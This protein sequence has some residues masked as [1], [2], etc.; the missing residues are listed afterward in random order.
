[1]VWFFPTNISFPVGA[2]PPMSEL[3]AMWWLC[4]LRGQ[5]TRTTTT[6]TSTIVINPRSYMVLGHKYQYGVDYGNY[7]HRV[8]EEIDAAPTLSLR[9]NSRHPYKSL[10]T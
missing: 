9:A 2:I 4:R 6:S 1:M 7:M 8:A 3:Q 10:Y 5:T